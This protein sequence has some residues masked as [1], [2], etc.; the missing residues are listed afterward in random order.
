ME[1]GPDGCPPPHLVDMELSVDEAMQIIKDNV[2][3]SNMGA[4]ETRVPP[5]V[6]SRLARGSKT[7]FLRLVFDRLK[8]EGFAPIF[9]NCNGSFIS[10]SC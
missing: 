4:G 7:T 1:A 10:I 2:A 8:Q 9:I 6:F 5:L 3:V